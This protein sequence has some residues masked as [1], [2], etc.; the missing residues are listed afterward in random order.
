M[1]QPKFLLVWIISGMFHI[2]KFDFWVSFFFENLY[3]QSSGR[4]SVVNYTA[5]WE[6]GTFYYTEAF[7]SRFLE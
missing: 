1:Q 6:N 7:L 2:L 3:K 5:S 4:I